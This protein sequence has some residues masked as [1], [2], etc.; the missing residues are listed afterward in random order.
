MPLLQVASSLKSTIDELANDKIF[1][2]CIVSDNAKAFQKAATLFQTQPD[3]AKEDSDDEGVEPE[4][5]DTDVWEAISGAME[6]LTTQGIFCCPCAAHSLQLVC[7]Q[8]CI[9]GSWLHCAQV[10]KDFE[11]KIPVVTSAVTTIRGMLDEFAATPERT[12]KFLQAQASLGLEPKQLCRIGQ[13]RCLCNQG[14]TAYHLISS[15]GGTALWMLGGLPF[16]FE[17]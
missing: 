14:H 1:V 7:W 5:G 8:C 17:M 4:E 10:L 11:A 3:N 6:T 12:A 13:T 9:V 2:F 15:T 16:S